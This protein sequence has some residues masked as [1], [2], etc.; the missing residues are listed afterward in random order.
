MKLYSEGSAP[1]AG[2]FFFYSLEA[3]QACWP[4]VGGGEESE[5]VKFSLVCKSHSRNVCLLFQGRI[6]ESGGPTEKKI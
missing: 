6:N 3:M 1:A 2:L 4:T 5:D